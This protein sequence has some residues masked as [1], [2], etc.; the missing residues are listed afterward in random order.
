V[1]APSA[2]PLYV[3]VPASQTEG[4][5]HLA[6]WIKRLKAPT[7]V[8][9]IQSGTP[10]KVGFAV[11]VPQRMVLLQCGNPVELRLLHVL[12]GDQRLERLLH[13][14]LKDSRVRRRSEWFDGPAVLPF[15]EYVDALANR[16]L[17]AWDGE[18]A[19]PNYEDFDPSLKRRPPKNAMKVR[20]VKPDPK[21][22]GETAEKMRRW[23]SG[24]TGYEMYGPLHPFAKAA[25]RR[26]RN[27]FD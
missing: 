20:Y 12:P 16:M 13:R 18:D 26:K 22:T 9:V 17:A 7:F 23:A 3:L 8:Y 25:I 15:L 1:D 21:V 10:I 19:A 24:A 27:P 2:S 4:E 11:N 14:K 6:L 5:R